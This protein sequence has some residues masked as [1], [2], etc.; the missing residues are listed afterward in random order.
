MIGVH[1]V[2]HAQFYFISKEF[3]VCVCVCHC[4][5]SLPMDVIVG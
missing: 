2:N 4:L 1:V 5:C 3:V